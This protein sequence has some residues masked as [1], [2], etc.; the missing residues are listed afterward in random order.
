MKQVLILASR[1]PQRRAILEQLGIS[2]EVVESGVEEDRAGDPETVVLLNA[3]RKAVA[4]LEPAPEGSV[5]LAADTEVVLDGRIY[6]KPADEQEARR[7]LDE[8]AGRTH[9][10]LSAL[11]LLGPVGRDPAGPVGPRASDRPDER[12]REASRVPERSGIAETAVTFRAADS[13]LVERYLASG[14]WR[15]RAGGYAIQGLGA[16][17]IERIE[18][19]YWNVVGLP[20]PLLIDLAPE[21]LAKS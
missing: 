14:E 9:I 2:F 12:L 6:G 20:V 19:D 13:G 18:G 3:R 10:V 16:G 5:I 1:S 15:E 7:F 4:A 11:V 8:L 21:L 17:L